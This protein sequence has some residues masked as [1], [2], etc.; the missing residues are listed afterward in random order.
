MIFGENRD[1]STG[2]TF[3]LFR[4]QT[5]SF[6]IFPGTER[7]TGHLSVSMTFFQSSQVQFC[8]S[9]AS[10]LNLKYQWT[11]SLELWWLL[12]LSLLTSFLVLQPLLW[13]D[14][15]ITIWASFP[16]LRDAHFSAHLRE[17]SEKS[18]S[19]TYISLVFRWPSWALQALPGLTRPVTFL[20]PGH[21]TLL[22]PYCDS[23]K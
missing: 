6:C 11:V 21:G 18:I 9:L 2:S 13:T 3:G 5:Q 14:F 22:C 7:Y 8:L 1:L 4:A 19:S 15:E 23:A 16:E 20:L 12:I 10:T 17:I